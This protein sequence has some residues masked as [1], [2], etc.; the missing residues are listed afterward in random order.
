MLIKT[1]SKVGLEGACLN[2]IKAVY[3]KPMANIILHVEKMKTFPLWSEA[4]QGCPFSSLV[5][6]I[7]L[8]VLAALIRQ[9]EE[10]HDIQIGKEKVKLSLFADDMKTYVENP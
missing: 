7:V 5:F 3:E 6:F 8:E 4:G 9:A 10:L 1:L 2:V